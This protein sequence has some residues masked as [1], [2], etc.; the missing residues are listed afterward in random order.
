MIG[1]QNIDL[2]Q[3]RGR[4]VAVSEFTTALEPILR[5]SIEDYDDADDDGWLLSFIGVE[6]VV[7]KPSWEIDQF[8][9]RLRPD[10]TI[11]C[12]DASNGFRIICR[13]IALIPGSEAWDAQ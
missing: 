12:E 7:M 8:E 6:E 3:F 4:D 13:E 2:A 5:L 9:T 10:N 11:E 1:H